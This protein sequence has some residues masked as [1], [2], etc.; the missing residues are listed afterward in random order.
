MRSISLP[1]R[2]TS[3]RIVHRGVSRAGLTR[4]RF[5][6]D[7]RGV[8]R[9]T[10]SGSL[11]AP[12]QSPPPLRAKSRQPGLSFRR[13]IPK[14]EA[15][16]EA[17]PSPARKGESSESKP[18][19]KTKRTANRAPKKA[20]K[21]SGAAAGKTGGKSGPVAKRD[22]AVS[23]PVLSKADME[24]WESE[25]VRLAEPPPPPA[26][27][28]FLPL[29]RYGFDALSKSPSMESRLSGRHGL[30]SFTSYAI[31]PEDILLRSI[32][33]SRPIAGLFHALAMQ[34]EIVGVRSFHGWTSP[35]IV[36]WAERRIPAELLAN[37]ETASQSDE[38]EQFTDLFHTL[39]A[40]SYTPDER[41]ARR[42]ESSLNMLGT[43]RRLYLVVGGHLIKS[44]R[45]GAGLGLDADS[46][47]A[48][49]RIP[50][51]RPGRSR[52]TVETNDWKWAKT[53]YSRFLDQRDRNL[54]ATKLIRAFF[55]ANRRAG[56][57]SKE[58]QH[59][60][61]ETLRKGHDQQW[62]ESRQRTQGES[63]DKTRVKG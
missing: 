16:S 51:K 60:L 21:K 44:G 38:S 30:N 33:R 61:L 10:R 39:G 14:S 24:R 3:A 15:M 26:I 12:G 11:P 40:F 48:N 62:R 37:L 17:D 31:P 6:A 50:Q 8:H 52:G 29:F 1:S 22:A 27:S 4:V 54:G 55:D 58:D 46:V 56:K 2:P 34:A 47:T 35:E 5:A 9:R 53:A 7:N 42:I 59:R 36:D 49:E 23:E 45:I 32:R 13:G 19:P 63:Q 25:F 18:A 20:A 28:D 41:R 57:L 43:I